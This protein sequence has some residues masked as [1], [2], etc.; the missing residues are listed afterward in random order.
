MLIPKIASGYN[1]VKYINFRVFSVC[2]AQCLSKKMSEVDSHWK[3][4]LINDFVC[5]N[6]LQLALSLSRAFIKSVVFSNRK[7]RLSQTVTSDCLFLILRAITMLNKVFKID[8]CK[9]SF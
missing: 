8:H 3:D 5:V 1:Q 9:S 4:I 7:G 6:R 2:I